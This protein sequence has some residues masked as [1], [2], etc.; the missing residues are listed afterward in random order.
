MEDI[1]HH[2]GQLCE[3]MQL[4]SSLP[5]HLHKKLMVCAERCDLVKEHFAKEYQELHKALTEQKETLN[6]HI[7][8]THV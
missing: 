7:K 1:K 5:D 2:L 6:E 4:R 3:D 8:A